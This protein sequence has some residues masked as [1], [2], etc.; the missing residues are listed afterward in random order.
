MRKEKIMVTPVDTKWDA[1]LYDNKHDFVFKYGEDLVDVLDPQEGEHILDLGCGTGYLT[2][3]V[4]QRGAEVTGIDNSAEM[5]AKA[6]TQYPGLDFRVQ[7]A[8]TFY[9]DKSFDAIFSNA[10]LHWVIEK[11]DAINCMYKNLKRN[12]RLVLEMGGKRNVEG[13][14]NA[15]CSA[16]IKRGFTDNANAQTWYFPSLSEYTSLL[17]NRGFRVTYAAHFNRETEL[18]DN[19]N[20]IKDWVK[21]FGSAYL[22]G[23]NE[24]VVNE[25][26]NEV[27]E[28]LKATHFKNGKWYADYKRL[29]IVA[30]KPASI[31]NGGSTIENIQP[32]AKK[33]VH[34]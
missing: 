6:K 34:Y 1:G 33:I 29:R 7:S 27:Q 25:I 14:I 31:P 4:A 20:G 15:L 26:L 2:N 8:T 17:E 12:G 16:L 21:M 10:V 18:K 3:L 30:V 13:I 32:L 5:I 24:S 19:E 11:E 28:T 23:I 9:F 22:K